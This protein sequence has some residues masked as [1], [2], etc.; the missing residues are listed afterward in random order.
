MRDESLNLQSD[1]TEYI[2]KFY[3]VLIDYHIKELKNAK[4]EYERIINLSYD[5][6]YEMYVNKF[7]DNREYYRKIADEAKKQ[8]AQY[9]SF[10]VIM[11]KKTRLILNIGYNKR[12]NLRVGGII[13]ECTQN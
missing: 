13:W 9:Q 4:A 6:L 10:Y 7:T 1:Y 11:Y 3:Q 12:K 5:E 2:K 8:N